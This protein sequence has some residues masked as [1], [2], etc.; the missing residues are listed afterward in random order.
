MSDEVNRI[1]AA[2][3]NVNELVAAITVASGDQARRVDSINAVVATMDDVVQ[4]SAASSEESSSAAEELAA[5]ANALAGMVSGFKLQ[6]Q[7]RTKRPELRLANESG[8]VV[9]LGER[10]RVR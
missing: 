3:K 1:L 10:G 4:Q 6:N 8:R 7:R 9:P 5:Q 2:M